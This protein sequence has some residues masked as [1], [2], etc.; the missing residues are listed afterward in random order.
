MRSNSSRCAIVAAIVAAVSLVAASCTSGTEDSQSTTTDPTTTLPE[1][2]TPEE[3]T[4][5]ESADVPAEEPP[6][7]AWIVQ[8][9]G[10]DT[11]R[12]ASVT[13]RNDSVLAVGDTRS[14]LGDGPPAES[15]AL[16]L[17]VDTAGEVI[18]L[19]HAGG[20]GEDEPRSVGF[21]SNSDLGDVTIACGST[22]SALSGP[23]AGLTD[24]WCGRIGAEGIESVHQQGSQQDDALVAVAID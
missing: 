17:V 5:D 6:E 21:G 10:P 1:G 24:A 2:Q 19:A 3:L 18:S 13:G 15:D 8:I 12:L 23:N 14:D 7:P 22:T 11:D 9:G 16:T 20:P 4:P